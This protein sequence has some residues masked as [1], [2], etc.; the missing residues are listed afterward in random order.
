MFVPSGGRLTGYSTSPQGGVVAFV[1][2]GGYIDSNTA[3]GLRSTLANEFHHLYVFNLRG[4]Q[5]L[6]ASWR[7][8]RREDF[9][10]WQPGHCGDH[11]ACQ[12]AGANAVQSEQRVL[13]R[14]IGDYL[15]RQQKL[16]ALAEALPGSGD[17]PPALDDLDWTAIKPEQAWRLDQSA[18]GILRGHLPI[19][20]RDGPSIF[21][22]R[23]NGLQTNRDAWNYNSSR[24]KLDE[25]LERMIEHYNASGGYVCRRSS[26]SDRNPASR[27]RKS[28]GASSTWIPSEF[29]WDRANFAD[30]ARG[31]H[32]ATSD[33]LRLDATYRPFHR[34]SADGRAL[35][36]KEA[37]QLHRVFP[38]DVSAQCSN[39]PSSA[40]LDGSA[41]CGTHVQ[42][43]H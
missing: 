5:R 40:R 43:A 3:D 17:V 15:T 38:D 19:H 39:L 28:Q 2:N 10:R 29:S 20:A 31:R 27:E 16:D 42:Y 8:G 14:D 34:R 12:A 30:V 32:Y 35:L 36:N 18:V 26:R 6:Q 23:S 33:A 7:A 1:T 22:I 37:S 25:N 21:E 24:A 13:Y 11:A 9:R 41:I 4:N